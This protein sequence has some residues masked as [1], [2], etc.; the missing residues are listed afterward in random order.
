M[1]KTLTILVGSI[2]LSGYASAAV[3]FS[4][5]EPNP[6]GS[7][8]ATQLVELSGG[9]PSSSFDLWILSI[10]NDGYNG[11]VDRASNVTGTFD[12]NGLALVTVNDL[13]NPSNTVILT[14]N[15]TGTTSTDID[16]LD[17]GVLVLTSMGAILDALGVSDAIAD[18]ATLYGGVLGGNDIL[19]N[20]EF[21]PLS[22]FRDGVTGDWYNT[23]TVDFGGIDEHVGVFAA[24]GGPE[25]DTA[26][27]NI[28]P[29]VTTLGSV[30]PTTIPEPSSAL[31][32]LLGCVVFFFR[33]T[34]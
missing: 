27:F 30:N 8:P 32:G 28:D 18:D 29:T 16:P 22:V 24:S 10:E 23:V 1:K 7:D 12:A 15:F 4:E 17:D 9:T 19:Y 20:G 25:L 3:V 11:L 26:I 21:E 31:L 6:P 13:E 34:R 5:F 33:R 2:A 14:D